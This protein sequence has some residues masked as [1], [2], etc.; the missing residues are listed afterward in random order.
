MASST[1]AQTD[2]VWP[3]YVAAMASLLLSLLLV[4]AVLV[5]TI[6]QIGNVNEL[7]EEQIAKIGFS[8]REEVDRLANLA[9]ISG[10][11]TEGDTSLNKD[12]LPSATQ[13]AQNAP[14]QTGISP[15]SREGLLGAKPTV[16]IDKLK[17]ALDLNLANFDPK[18][19]KDL[20]RLVAS[21]VNLLQQID[22]S[23]VDVRKIK[24]T[25]LDLTKID[26][27]RN[28]A[29]QDLKK[30]DF[31][32]VDFGQLT[33]QRIEILKPFIAKEGIRYRLLEQQQEKQRIKPVKE[34]PPPPAP[35]PVALPS[36]PPEKPKPEPLLPEKLQIKY[37][38]EAKDPSPEQKKK[39]VQAMEVMYRQYGA[40]RI[41]TPLPNDDIYLKR[42]AFSR[43]TA[44]RAMALEAGFTSSRV[45][46]AIDVVP[47]SS[48][49]Q[50]D[51]TL[52]VA[53]LKK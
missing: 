13:P 6:S 10:K 40:I 49:P 5:V 12:G 4:A 39:I 29:A 48:M 53:E 11:T 38:E 8:S 2:I 32:Q 9:G 44:L 27:S 45:Q 18:A 51:M 37:I 1:N 26:L 15:A 16:E 34:P 33:P 19:A 28:I 46:I 50:R 21:D 36:P 17:K 30:I 23:K 42:T 35:A 22:L 43:L 24:F 52:F 7:Y 31:S 3:G 41:W 20:A 25:G 14:G 47:G